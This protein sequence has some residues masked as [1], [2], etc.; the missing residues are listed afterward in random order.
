MSANRSHFACNMVSGPL[1]PPTV[2]GV[3]GVPV[4]IPKGPVSGL[5]GPEIPDPK[6]ALFKMLRM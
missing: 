2:R 6:R 1:S 3:F 5:S 4:V